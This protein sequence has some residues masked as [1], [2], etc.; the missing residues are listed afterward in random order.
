MPTI[1]DLDAIEARATAATPG[2][3]A[4]YDLA[5]ATYGPE[6]GTGWWWVWQE[7][8]LPYFGGVLKLEDEGEPGGAIG[9][10]SIDDNR[11]GA[12]ER[13]DA[14]FIAHAREDVPALVA[15][16]R[17]VRAKLAA[18]RAIHVDAGRSQGYLPSGDYGYIDHTCAVCGTLGE[19]A[20]S[21]PCATARALGIGATE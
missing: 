8:R 4:P 12:Q 18:V 19:Y 5:D 3:W 21:W 14:E 16:L 1:L 15:E 11:S 6:D 10:A 13:S 17:E 20:E 7:S 9:E 2:P